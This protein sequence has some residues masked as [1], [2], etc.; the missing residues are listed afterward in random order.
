MDAFEALARSGIR[1]GFTTGFSQT[2]ARPLLDALGWPT[3]ILATSD[4]VSHGR[5]APDLIRLG[6]RQAACALPAR[7]G[8]AGDTPSDLQAGAAA[9]CA[10]IIGVGHGSHTL[11]EL[12]PHP[13]TH[14]LP[15]L[16]NFAEVLHAFA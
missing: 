10:L 12:A 16:S 8:I 15:D 4:M 6:M 9:G 3:S 14:L 11:A 2:T 7:V 5:P 13:H 1:F